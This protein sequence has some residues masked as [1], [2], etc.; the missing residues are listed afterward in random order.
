MPSLNSIVQPYIENGSILGAAAAILQEGEV[1]YLGGF[2][3]TSVE[4]NGVRVTPE[5]LF[6]YGSIGKTLCATLIMRLAEQGRVDL[7]R[8]VIQYLPGLQFSD[9]V[10][11]QKVT[12]RP[13]R[14]ASSRESSRCGT[15][16]MTGW[17][18]SSRSSAT[19]G[20]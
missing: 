15:A 17:S 4:E 20:G 11:G 19:T 7:D 9:R 14:S 5:T 18:T 13:G 8:P 1:V 3:R 10:Y 6:A 16:S 2:G 12:L